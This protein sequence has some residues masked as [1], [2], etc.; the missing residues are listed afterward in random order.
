MH[1]M[2]TPESIVIQCD[3]PT[4]VIVTVNSV[5][6]LLSRDIRRSF[7]HLKLMILS[8]YGVAGLHSRFN[9]RS[10][11]E[12]LEES[13]DLLE[14]QPIASGEVEGMRFELFEKPGALDGDSLGPEC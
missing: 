12:I 11:A 10:V 5:M 7:N 9:G 1:E 14:S 3:G 13:K 6:P 8:Q 4:E 2:K